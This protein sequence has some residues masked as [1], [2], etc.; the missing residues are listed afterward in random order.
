MAKNLPKKIV[1]SILIIILFLLLRINFCSS[2]YKT[3]NTIIDATLNNDLDLVLKPWATDLVSI[4]AWL[5][6]GSLQENSKTNGLAH[7]VEHMIFKQ[8][9]L[10]KNIE[11]R[12]GYFNAATSQDF[13][14]YYITIPKKEVYYVLTVL[15]EL[16]FNNNFSETDFITEKKV[17]LEEIQRSNENPDSQIYNYINSSI[18]RDHPYG[19]KV[20]GE[21]KNIE[22]YTLEELNKFYKR[23]Y[24]PN[25]TSIII[26]GGFNKREIINYLKLYEKYAKEVIPA[27]IIRD[28]NYTGLTYTKQIKN[29]TLPTYIYAY[30]VPGIDSE[31]S[32]ILDVLM[33]LLGNRENS[34]L[35]RRLKEE[36][37]LSYLISAGYQTKKKRSLFLIEIPLKNLAALNNLKYEYKKLIDNFSVNE[38]ELNQ[39]KTRLA[40]EYY[41]DLE[42]VENVGSALGYYHSLASYKYWRDYL[43][44]INK[45][46]VLDL[47]NVIK[48]YFHN[49]ATFLFIPG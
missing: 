9:E 11:A 26:T 2:E 37:D 22:T 10:V 14:Y 18:Y 27:A 40:K 49:P 41:L 19:Q 23:Y 33:Y 48:K 43:V 4:Q 29:L 3:D 12:G 15:G 45:V 5:R 16:L 42:K 1:A 38:T 31:D 44:K 20:I 24:L 13:T 28:K 25:N 34:I 47:N 39:V 17:I 46:T 7:F 21:K 8:K 6:T 30:S 36:L 35:N 32:Y